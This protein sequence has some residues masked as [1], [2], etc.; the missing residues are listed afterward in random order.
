MYTDG[1]A[2]HVLYPEAVVASGAAFQIDSEGK[3]RIYR[4]RAP[5]D[6]P[7][8]A[9]SGEAIGLSLA[10]LGL[11]RD[12]RHVEELTPH[13]LDCQAP[14]NLSERSP[15]DSSKYAGPFRE[16]VMQHTD[17]FKAL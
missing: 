1:S 8:T 4:A 10:C 17:F 15:H 9:I 6:Q 2:K 3:Q 5:P 12:P 14:I 16:A 7:Q 13:V 11:E